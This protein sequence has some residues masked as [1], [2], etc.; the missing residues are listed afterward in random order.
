M[1]NIG[2]QYPFRGFKL[3]LMNPQQDIQENQM[4]FP[5]NNTLPCM[6]SERQASNIIL[7]LLRNPR[8]KYV[9]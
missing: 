8:A 7:L 4:E 3:K 6:H 9:T 2:S 1:V 5:Q